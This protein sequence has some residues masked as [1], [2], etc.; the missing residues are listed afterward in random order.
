MATSSITLTFPFKSS[1]KESYRNN[2][3]DKS[4]TNP[5][6]PLESSIESKVSLDKQTK[7]TAEI[8]AIKSYK[9]VPI[10][11]IIC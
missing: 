4:G 6:K 10:L 11:P 1:T 5:M 2:G 7:E 9:N 3:K 8:L